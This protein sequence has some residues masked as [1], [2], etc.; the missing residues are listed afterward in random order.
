MDGVLDLDLLLRL[1]L[2]L[3][4]SL[5]GDLDFDF[6]TEAER[7]G[8]RLLVRRLWD[9]HISSQITIVIKIHETQVEHAYP[10]YSA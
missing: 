8:E 3:S 9:N 4:R 2:R 1:F 6:L 5:D 10:G 7:D